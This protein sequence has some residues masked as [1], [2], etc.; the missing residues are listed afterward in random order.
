MTF[1]LP[2]DWIQ[3]VDVIISEFP[4]LTYLFEDQG[5]IVQECFKSL[6][7]LGSLFSLLY[8]PLSPL[9]SK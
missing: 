6:T 9:S 4:W 8:G 7:P 5:Q 2:A 3:N 1:L